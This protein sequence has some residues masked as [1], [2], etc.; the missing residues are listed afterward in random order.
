MRLT[1]VR[2]AALALGPLLAC[3]EPAAPPPPEPV[4]VENPDLALAIAALPEPFEVVTARGEA[5]ELTAP[6]ANGPGTLRI[7]LGPPS[8]S[9]INLVEAAKQGKEG[10]ETAPGGQFYGHR[11]LGGSLGNVFTARGGYRLDDGSEVEETRAYALHPIEKNRMLTI[12]YT[13]P[14]GESQERVNQFLYLLGE[15]EGLMP[16]DAAAEAG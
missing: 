3:G 9:G 13:Y 12:V 4:R 14:P 8:P 1:A 15:I 11:T 7:T 10:F 16:P 6:G 5:I 2:F